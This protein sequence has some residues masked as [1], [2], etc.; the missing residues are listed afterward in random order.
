MN[1]E[2]ENRDIVV[3]NFLEVMKNNRY[4]KE[5]QTQRGSQIIRLHK[6]LM[7]EDTVKKV[8]SSRD[9]K[10]VEGFVL[11]LATIPEE[12]KQDFNLIVEDAQQKEIAK[13]EE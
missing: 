2:N 11:A 3:N 10:V 9:K 1:N 7:S 8:F 12:R 6:D 4:N 13:A 5:L